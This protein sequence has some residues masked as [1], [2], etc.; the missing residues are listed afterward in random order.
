[1]MFLALPLVAGYSSYYQKPQKP[2]GAYCM[3]SDCC[4]CPT[5]ERHNEL[6]TTQ[7]YPI[8]CL[9]SPFFY[10]AHPETPIENVGAD[11]LQCSQRRPG[12]PCVPPSA[13]AGCGGEIV[14]SC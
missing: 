1:M 6:G 14:A 4:I 9:D 12:L 10:A 13:G 2:S 8:N 11:I 5:Q 3:P 7:S